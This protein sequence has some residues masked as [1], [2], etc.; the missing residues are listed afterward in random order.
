M[1]IKCEHCG[2]KYYQAGIENHI[3]YAHSIRS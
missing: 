1:K 3:K 2:K